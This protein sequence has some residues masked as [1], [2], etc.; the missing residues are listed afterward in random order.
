M[1][2]NRHR[3]YAP[4]IGRFIS[5]DPIGLLGGHNV[6]AYAPN[7]VE[8][9]DPR[10]LSKTKGKSGNKNTE[11]AK[12][13]QP[14]PN[15]CKNSTA[16]LDAKGYQTPLPGSKSPYT[17]Q[18]TWKNI[19]IKPGTEFY[20]LHPHGR[21]QNPLENAT[22]NFFVRKSQMNRYPSATAY[23]DAVQVAHK[24]NLA[25]SEYDMRTEMHKFTVTK[26][27]CAAIAV[28]KA[29]SHI[30]SGGAIQYYVRDSDTK[31]LRQSGSLTKLN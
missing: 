27:F 6:Y 21:S 30:S 16:A 5:K 29:N 23:N 18:D 7:P 11:S 3:Y 2:Y 31:N 25:S 20:A 1:H 10:G 28:A 17:N 26:G 13:K 9:V 14:C 24:G 19:W 8:W 4:N 12:K 22:P 15:P